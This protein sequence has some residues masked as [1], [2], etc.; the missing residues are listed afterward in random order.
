[1]PD[2]YIKV[3]DITVDNTTYH[4][5]VRLHI[6][7]K[8]SDATIYAVSV[9]GIGKMSKCNLTDSDPTSPNLT[10]T[11]GPWTIKAGEDK[12]LVCI[13]SGNAVPGTSY[14]VKVYTKNGNVFTA[15]LTA[16]QG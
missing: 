10:Y 16:Q 6:V 14:T 11:T 2:S 5:T 1:M 15:T 4:Y 12:W 3:E 8:G 9:S 13:G 7:N